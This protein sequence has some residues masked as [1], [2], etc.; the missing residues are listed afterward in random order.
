M[1]YP[2]YENYKESGSKYISVIPDT[3][4]TS[5]IKY[6]VCTPI[7][8]G[9]HETPDFLEEGIPFISAEAIEN[10][11]INFNKK[12]DCISKEQHKIY[13]KK[14]KPQ[15]ND[16]YVVKSGS[17]TGK[18]AIV[19]TE[20]EFN[21]WSPLAAIRVNP[22]KNDPYFLFYA[23]SSD[24]FQKQVSLF[25]SFGTQPNIGMGVLQKLK[26]PTPSLKEQNS[27]ANFLDIETT[28]L[29]ALIT[30]KQQLI[31]TLKEKRSAIISHSVTKGLNTNVKMKESG[32]EWIG[33]I[34]ESWKTSPIKF[35]V[36]TPITDGPHITPDF[37]DDGILFISAEAI[38]YGKINF[39]KKR[40]FIS[41]ED[42][43]LFH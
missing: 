37:I 3:W 30:K 27:I 23:V 6:L 22:E 39:N 34:P 1:K 12:R 38:E 28:R 24:L 16:V 5:A 17:T 42:H 20:D 8:D 15:K 35:I 26:I 13:S 25:W 31:E 10:G 7:T 4:T 29:D 43:K 2:Q 41:E 33:K 32:I 14:Y 36:S 18:V 9:P 40:G 11:R 19:D 21:I